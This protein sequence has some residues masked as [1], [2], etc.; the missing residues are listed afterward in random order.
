MSDRA[1]AEAVGLTAKV[2]AAIRRSTEAAAQSDV[3]VGRDGR[4]R[5]L[6]GAA[7]RL[8]VA[9]LVAEHPEASLREV[10][11]LAGVSPGTVRDVRRRLERGESPVPERPAP[12][13]P[14]S[15]LVPESPFVPGPEPEPARDAISTEPPAT[16]TADLLRMFERDAFVVRLLRGGATAPAT[17]APAVVRLAYQNAQ[18]WLDFALAV[19][20]NTRTV[21]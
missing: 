10:A 17:Y 20:Q 5:P 8:R 7:G 3:R 19:D 14:E 18:M 1:I 4:T 2:V 9:A 6:N 12:S 15:E 16:D 13:V 21:H 11:R